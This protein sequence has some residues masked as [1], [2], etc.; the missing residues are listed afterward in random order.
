MGRAKDKSKIKSS[1]ANPNSNED[2]ALRDV[3][4]LILILRGFNNRLQRINHELDVRHAQLDRMAAQKLAWLNHLPITLLGFV[5]CV[6]FL[7]KCKADPTWIQ[8]IL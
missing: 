5:A 7:F 2:N 8:Y 1:E 6:V 3:M 4:D